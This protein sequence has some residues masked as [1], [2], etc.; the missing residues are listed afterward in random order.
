MASVEYIISLCVVCNVNKTKIENDDKEPSEDLHQAAGRVHPVEAAGVPVQPHHGHGAALAPT[1]LGCDA[2]GIPRLLL[3][4]L[5]RDLHRT[6]RFALSKL[7]KII[8]T[9]FL[10]LLHVVDGQFVSLL[11]RGKHQ[12]YVVDCGEHDA[13][14]MVLG[15]DDMN[16][17][18]AAFLACLV[19]CFSS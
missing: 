5:A 19:C 3:P 7:T 11:F 12:Q 14:W 10:R 18:R 6:R 2:L 4:L 1:G 8:C 16:F 17:F 9:T 13:V 15:C